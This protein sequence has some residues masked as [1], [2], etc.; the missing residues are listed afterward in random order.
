MLKRS[1]KSWLSN[2]RT[3]T[4]TTFYTHILMATIYYCTNFMNYDIYLLH[5]IQHYNDSISRLIYNKL[6]P[7]L[8]ISMYITFS[9]LLFLNFSTSTNNH[10]Q[11]SS[12][13]PSWYTPHQFRAV[14]K[15]LAT[16][17]TTTT[18]TTTASANT[19]ID[20]V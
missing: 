18:T 11:H 7:L 3:Y 10:L 19:C 2:I 15:S 6:M 4:L 13:H 17:T 14:T 1:L 16:G 5:Y 12:W 20:P 9:L 8:Y